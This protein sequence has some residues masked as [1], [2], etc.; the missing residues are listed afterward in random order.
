MFRRKH[1]LKS[2]TFAFRL[3]SRVLRNKL[4]SRLNCLNNVVLPD[5]VSTLMSKISNEFNSSRFHTQ[6]CISKIKVLRNCRAYNSTS[7]KSL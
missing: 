4:L 6:L 1:V 7:A 5:M 2:N 3:K